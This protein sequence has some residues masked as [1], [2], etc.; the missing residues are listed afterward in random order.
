[1]L[2]SL[3]IAD[4]STLGQGEDL[5]IGSHLA[6]VPEANVH[7]MHHEHEE[8]DEDENGELPTVK[9]RNSASWGQ[10]HPCSD[11]SDVARN[12]GNVLEVRHSMLITSHWQRRTLVHMSGS[13]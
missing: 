1:M 2:L 12:T 5:H 4:W 8:H 6:R 11:V 3:T 13:V 7:P 10:E 9:V